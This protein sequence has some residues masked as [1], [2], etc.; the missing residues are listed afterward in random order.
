MALYGNRHRTVSS[1]CIPTFL[2]WTSG[3]HADRA[4]LDRAHGPD[5]HSA[6]LPDFG[7]WATVSPFPPRTPKPER[8]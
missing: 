5:A 8:M 4:P 2:S 7:F 6:Y 3:F 1:L